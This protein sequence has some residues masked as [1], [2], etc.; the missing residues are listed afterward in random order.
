MKYI[1]ITGGVLSGIGKGTI[2]SSLCHILSNSGL[3]VTALKIDPYLNYDAGTMNPYQHGEVFVLDDGSEVDLDLGNYERYLDRT[4]TGNNNITTGKVYKEVIERER[5]GEYLGS[6]VQIIPHITNEIK[7]RIRKVATEPDL[8]L[9]VIEVGG[10]VGDI[11][12]MPFLEALRQMKREE[13]G[14]V[15]FCHVTL[16]PEIGGE[17]EQKTKPT[18]HSVR[19]LKEIGIQPDLLM[20]R[21]RKPLSEDS[22]RRIS[23]FT[24]VAEEAV[25]SV[26][27]VNNAY[28]VPQVIE[29]QGVI[30]IIKKQLN[31]TSKPFQDSWVEYKKNLLH[32]GSYVNIGI[33]GKYTKLHDA[34]ISHREAMMHATGKTGIGVNI[35]WL[36]ADDVVE[37]PNVLESLDGILVTPGFGYRGVEGKIIAAKYARETGTPYLGICLGFQVAVI[38]FARNVLGLKDANSSEFSSNLENAVIDI[39]P[40]QIGIRDMGG[41]MRLGSKKVL[42]KDDTLAYDLYG[43]NEIHERHRHRYEVNPAYIER[44]EAAGLKFS[45]TDEEGVRMEIAEIKGNRSYISSQFHAEFKSRPLNPSP[46]H[47]HFVKMAGEF[48]KKRNSPEMKAH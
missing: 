14:E 36:D 23:L 40:E 33:I 38:E 34:Y 31:L 24:D 32:P 45:G 27:D 4:L 29:E 9:V 19:S 3:R 37:N 11:E 12:S 13:K 48:N 47:L 21:S 10:T 17:G 26:Y 15:V 2:A 39:L 30:E 22:K 6:T 8:D 46:L 18:Q 25:I 41:T 43:K 44:L 5:R 16:I 20:C 28:E 42:V 35:I 7:R 1:V